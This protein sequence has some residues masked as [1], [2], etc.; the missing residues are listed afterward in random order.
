MIPGPAQYLLRFDDLCPT[1]SRARWQRF[2]LVIEEFGIHPILAVVPEN[3]DPDLAVAEPDEEF[4]AEMRR[5]ETAGAT[6]GLHGFRHLSCSRGRSLVPIHRLSEFAGVPR[7]TQRLWI[8]SGLQIL[9]QHGLNPKIWVAPRHGFDRNT[10]AALREEEIT[11][12][13]DGFARFPFTCDGLTWIPQQLWAPMEKSAGTWTICIHSNTASDLHVRQV[14]DFVREHFAQ[15]TS[16]ERLQSGMPAARLGVFER[17]YGMS[18]LLR[19]Q[20]NRSVKRL[21]GKNARTA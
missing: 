21:L 10:L 8:R 12:L 4:W 20:V 6:I 17:L 9:R 5:L 18:T 15:F 7:G 11:L 19:I 14:E 1:M 3:Q 13:S 2:L 16:V